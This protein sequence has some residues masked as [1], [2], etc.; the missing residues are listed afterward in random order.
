MT[1]CS[2]ALLT[3]DPAISSSGFLR[4]AVIDVYRLSWF[5]CMGLADN[6]LI[7]CYLIVNNPP[8]DRKVAGWNLSVHT[9]RYQEFRSSSE[10][11][12]VPV[13]RRGVPMLPAEPIGDNRGGWTRVSNETIRES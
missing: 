3:E 5:F 7:F 8:T 12:V 4:E 2:T 1:I 13:F 6:C 9:R 11:V 10:S